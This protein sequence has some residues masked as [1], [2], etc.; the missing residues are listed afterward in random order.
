M[1]K[2][3]AVGVQEDHNVVA[4]RLPGLIGF[5]LLLL[6][7]SSCAG[8]QL[9]ACAEPPPFYLHLEAADRV[10]P[11][12]RGRSMPTVV[13][14]FQLKDTLR[15]EQASFQKLWNKPEAL[16]EEDLLQ[17]AE[18]TVPPNQSIGRWIQR[19]PQARYVAVMGLFRQPLGYAWRTLT[20]LPTVSKSQCGQQP[21]AERGL[22]RSTDE[23][24]RFKLQGYQIDL[25]KTGPSQGRGRTFEDP[26]PSEQ[27]PFRRKT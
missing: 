4:R 21:E 20:V 11:D 16:L 23:Q 1:S 6:A 5:C 22:P 10:N 7:C 12:P 24:L 18:F 14:L 27:P 13:Q 2:A 9:A 26:N 3:C 17:V 8:K 25:L 15:V 19:D